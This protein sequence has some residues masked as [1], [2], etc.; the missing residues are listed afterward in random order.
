[1][2]GEE[3]GVAMISTPPKLVRLALRLGQRCAP[4]GPYGGCMSL[5]TVLLLVS[6]S[7]G[8]AG[9]TGAAPTRV[10]PSPVLTPLAAPPQDCALTAPPQ[11]MTVAQLG[12][13]ANA[14]LVGGG[15]FWIYGDFFQRV[16]HIGQ[17]FG[18]Q[19]W[20]IT[21]VVVEVGP[22]YD[23]PVTLRLRELRTGALAW[24]TDAQKPPVAATQTLTLDPQQDMESVGEI[25]GLP[26][27]PHGEVASGWWEWGVFPLFTVAGCYAWEAHW[28]GGSWQSVI[29]VGN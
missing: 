10:L 8:G 12:P 2:P 29:A 13:N 19:R 9:V 11:T 6:C 24:W 23:Q 5:V 27:V 14:E 3:R 26:D 28:S 25:P 15:V 4:L 17:Y 1:M 21:K 22:N 7:S 20:P 16:L 18:D